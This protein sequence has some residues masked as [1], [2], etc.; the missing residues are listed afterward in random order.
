VSDLWVDRARRELLTRRVPDGSWG[1]RDGVSSAVEPTALAGLA[2]LASE[3]GSGH[4]PSGTPASEVSREAAAWLAGL[5]RGDGSLPAAP[6]P[7]MPGWATPHAMLLWSRLDGFEDRRRRAR[8]WLVSAQDRPLAYSAKDRTAIGHDA[9]LIGWSWVAGTHSWLEPT[10]MAVIALCGEGCRDHLRV[11]RGLS[12][13]VD[14]AIAGGGW[15]YGN[16]IIFGQVLRPQPGPT[17]MALLALAAGGPSDCVV[18]PPALDY[19]RCTLPSIRAAASVGWGVLGLKAHRACP[20]EAASW[21]EAAHERCTGRPDATIGLSLLL[22]AADRGALPAASGA[23][24][25]QG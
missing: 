16:N 1:Y 8:E 24:A 4:P 14:R 2:L 13:I 3:E 25:P 9:T 22:L 20:P 11:R 18:V 6:G 17:G 7:A 10:A 21:L 5:Q 19:L 15:N 23:S 12:L